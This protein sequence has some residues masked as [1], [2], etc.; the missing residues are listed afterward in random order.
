MSEL[1]VPLSTAVQ[2]GNELFQTTHGCV[3]KAEGEVLHLTAAARC[4]ALAR[5]R[6]SF[7]VNF[8]VPSVFIIIARPARAKLFSAK[9]NKDIAERRA[10]LYISDR[11]DNR[12]RVDRLSAAAPVI[13]LRNRS[14]GLWRRRRWSA[15]RCDGNWRVRI[16]GTVSG[17]NGT[18]MLQNNGSDSLSVSANGI[19]T[20]PALIANRSAFSVAVL[21]QPAG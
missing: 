8:L 1:Q 3:R 9:S 10:P 15:C 11:R 14:C 12:M 16:G 13:T 7:G 18:V 2:D 17:L 20:F 6:Y 21:T 19:F 5:V 4:K